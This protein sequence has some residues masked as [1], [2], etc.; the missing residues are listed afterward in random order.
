MAASFDKL[1]PVYETLEKFTFGDALQ[2]ARI[3]CIPRLVRAGTVLCAGE[4]DGRLAAAILERYPD[5][6]LTLV[7][8]SAAMLRRARRRIKGLSGRDARVRYEQDDLL[9]AGPAAWRRRRYDAVCTPF[10]LDCFV[11]RQLEVLVP[12][13][14]GVLNPGGRWLLADFTPL[15]NRHVPR[16]GGVERHAQDLLV[17]GLY[18]FFRLSTGIEARQV[19]DPLPF[20]EAAGGRLLETRKFLNGLI[21]SACFQWRDIESSPAADRPG[22]PAK[23]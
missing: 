13:L 9:V 1:A 14:A 3:A 15:P 22:S 7:D 12:A 16:P 5:I 4:G 10:L 2:R 18:A 11:P 6:E 17:Q 19:E 23:P 21:W 20:L 8:A